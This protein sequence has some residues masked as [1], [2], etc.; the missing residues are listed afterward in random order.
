MRPPVLEALVQD[1]GVLVNRLGRAWSAC[2]GDLPAELGPT[3]IG[4]APGEVRV[5]LG[6]AQFR[7]P[8]PTGRAG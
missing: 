3:P 6:E 8:V 1:V 7:Q 2:F 5:R 4:G